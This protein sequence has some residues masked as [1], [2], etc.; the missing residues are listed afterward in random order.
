MEYFSD[1]R[2]IVAKSERQY[3]LEILDAGYY[4]ISKM[5]LRARESVFWPGILN[6]I[7]TLA[8]T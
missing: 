6:D 5:T 8:E 7:K 4:G 1:Y 2:L 3:I